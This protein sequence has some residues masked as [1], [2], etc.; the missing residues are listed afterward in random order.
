M[1]RVDFKA[2]VFPSVRSSLGF[3]AKIRKW[4]KRKESREVKKL[5][6]KHI[7]SALLLMNM[8]ASRKKE[9][10]FSR[11]TNCSSFKCLHT[12]TCKVVTNNSI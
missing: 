6:S 1:I 4:I 5:K 3:Y 2:H 8:N 10:K 11:N 12:D 9:Q 7:A